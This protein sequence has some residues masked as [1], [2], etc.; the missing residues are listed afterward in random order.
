[1]DELWAK[2]TAGGEESM[3]GW[4][5][6]KYGLSW[7]IVP[8][9]LI[10][11]MQDEDPVKAKR[12]TEAM[13][14]MRKIDIEKLQQAYAGTTECRVGI[15][16]WLVFV[17]D[18]NSPASSPT[19]SWS[20]RSIT[21]RKIIVAE[22]ISFDGV[23]QAPGGADEDTDGGFTHGGWTWPY[24]HDDIGE[25]FF[26]AISQCD[27]F[28]LGRKTW[29]IHGGAFEPMAVGDPFGDVMNSIHK[30][31][32]STTLQSTSAWRN[33][34][35][36]SRNVVEEVRK[37]K[38][39]PGKNILVDGSSVLVHTL[40]QHDLVDEYTF[41]VYPV[42]LGSGKRVFPDGLRVNMKLVE[43]KPLPSGVVWMRYQPDRIE[44][45]RA[46]SHCRQRMAPPANCRFQN[47]SAKIRLH[48]RRNRQESNRCRSA[49]NDHHRQRD[50]VAPVC[51]G[52]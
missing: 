41:H 8:R 4:L 29:Q 32:V 7:Q 22:F 28:L 36:I 37:L 23:M 43:S 35:L 40:A 30:Y 51:G 10:E 31:V 13:L 12:V 21:M 34:T 3:C 49:G 11:L 25:H 5:K 18:L 1:M 17:R 38:E 9:V 46:R 50:A 45:R 42:V 24:W 27:A 44:D 39:Q 52:D 20:K 19:F 14:Q 33:S 2:L 26:Q 15:L 47:R 48:A 6:D 16:T